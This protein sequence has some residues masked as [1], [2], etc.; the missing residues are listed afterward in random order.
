MKKNSSPISITILLSIFITVF[1]SCHQDPTAEIIFYNRKIQ[2]LQDYNNG[3]RPNVGAPDVLVCMHDGTTCYVSPPHIPAPSGTNFSNGYRYF[4]SI[5]NNP[6]AIRD[7]F[8][9]DANV[10][11]FFGNHP[12]Y[13]NILSGI[14]N[15]LIHFVFQDNIIIA[16]TGT[17]FNIDTNLVTAIDISTY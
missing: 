10:Q 6:A 17:T 15:G 9:N 8:S 3:L 4:V 1:L 5:I 13:S 7:F 11:A 2:K 12:N 16:H 14:Q